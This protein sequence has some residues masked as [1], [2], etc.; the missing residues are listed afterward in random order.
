MIDKL[1]ELAIG[2]GI[3]IRDIYESGRFSTSVKSDN[4]PVTSADEEANEMILRGLNQQFPKI[5]AISEESE[6]RALEL[7]LIH[8]SEPRD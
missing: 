8:I 6:N 2:A 1:I 5:P 3:I 4:T 7:S